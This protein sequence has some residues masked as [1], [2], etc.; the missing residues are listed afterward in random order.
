MKKLQDSPGGAQ[1]FLEYAQLQQQMEGNISPRS[2]AV[3]PGMGLS[4]AKAGTKRNV[5]KSKPAPK[6]RTHASSQGKSIVVKK[7]VLQNKKK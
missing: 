6:S 7:S 5:S 2:K 4:P 3:T 1:G